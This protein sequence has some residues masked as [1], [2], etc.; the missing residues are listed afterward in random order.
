MGFHGIPRHFKATPQVPWDTFRG[1]R[2]TR[3]DLWRVC[4][5]VVGSS[6]NSWHLPGVPRDTRGTTE[7]MGQT[8]GIEEGSDPWRIGTVAVIGCYW[9]WL[10]LLVVIIVI[11]S[12][13]CCLWRYPSHHSPWSGSQP[14]TE[15]R[16]GRDRSWGADRVVSHKVPMGDVENLCTDGLKTYDEAGSIGGLAFVYLFGVFHRGDPLWTFRWLGLCLASC[17]A[18]SL[19]RLVHDVQDLFC[20]FC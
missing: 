7:V 15:G 5:D 16:D 4:P 19:K 17:L 20:S 14:T 6:G 11:G 13:G 8:Q 18:S 12:I 9:Y 1:H 10:L 2:R 3:H